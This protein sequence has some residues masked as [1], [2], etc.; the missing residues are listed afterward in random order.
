MARIF[1][2]I[3]ALLFTKWFAYQ[4][5]SGHIRS[6]IVT[7]GNIDVV[8]DV[9]GLTLLDDSIAIYY[10]SNIINALAITGNVP[11]SLVKCRV[12]NGRTK[13][14]LSNVDKLGYFTLSVKDTTESGHQW[15]PIIFLCPVE[16]KQTYSIRLFKS[17]RDQYS[18]KIDYTATGEGAATIQCFKE[19]DSIS[20]TTKG[21]FRFL[22]PVLEFDDSNYVDIRK[23]E[24]Q[25]VLGSYRK[26]LSVDLYRLFECDISYYQQ[27]L[28]YED[29][30]RVGKTLRSD[31][32]LIRLR[33]TFLSSYEL[34][35][36]VS[37]TISMIS[38]CAPRTLVVKAI[39][40]EFIENQG[41]DYNVVYSQLVRNY[42]GIIR[43]KCLLYFLGTY[44]RVMSDYD[45]LLCDSRKY[46]TSDSFKPYLVR[47][48]S[49]VDGRLA[50]NFSLPD[51]N[52]RLISLHN[53]RGKVVFIDFWFT[54]CSPCKFFYLNHL[55][56]VEQRFKNDSNVVFVTI[57]IDRRLATW[58]ASVA[59]GEYTS[60][61]VVNLFTEGMASSHPAI[62][63]FAIRGYPSPLLIDKQGR[64][65]KPGKLAD[66]TN[67]DT[68]INAISNLV[69]RDESFNKTVKRKDVSNRLIHP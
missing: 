33:R 21:R 63:N 50:Y 37:D 20:K 61:D 16:E 13:I 27:W 19:M 66:L 57:S 5:Y 44:G 24:L 29:V 22:D 45:S 43:Q 7:E 12:V 32:L 52:G 8:V 53:F 35:M 11:S 42:A 64:V 9:E 67:S 55:K 62:Q 30:V 14:S 18:D 17:S 26:M 58:R 25:S 56:R 54:G 38:K 10:Y 31:S 40:D 51:Y 39:A 47:L 49:I 2:L 15:S 41:V 3:V 34:S 28:K 48:N 36:Q 6:G 59:S 69:G 4:A 68:L 1:I 65:F 23:K 60:T 46:I